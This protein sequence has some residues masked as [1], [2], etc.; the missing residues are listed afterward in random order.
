MIRNSNIAKFI[1]NIELIIPKVSSDY[2]EIWAREYPPPKIDVYTTNQE[3]IKFIIDEKKKIDKFLLYIH[4]PF[5]E[6]KCDYCNYYCGNSID[7]FG[8][9]NYVDCL[10]KEIELN[11]PNNIKKEVISIYFGGGTPSLLNPHDLERL[12]IYLKDKFKLLEGLP[13]TFECS[14]RTV[15]IELAKILKKI[16]VNRI[17]MG[18]Q[19]FNEEILKNV[20]RIQTN[21]DVYNAIKHLRDEGNNN[22]NIE[23]IFGLSYN[24]TITSF[25]NDNAYHLD[26]IM[27]ES[28]MIYKL[29]NYKKHPEM[30]FKTDYESDLL[31]EEMINNI[32]SKSLKFR[33]MIKPIRYPNLPYLINGNVQSDMKNNKHIN[34]LAF[35]LGGGSR[36]WIN[37]QHVKIRHKTNDLNEY[38]FNLVNNILAYKYR[39]LSIDESI[40]KDIIRRLF[41][42]INIRE[43]K[44]LFNNEFDK[45]KTILDKTEN[46]LIEN[47]GIITLKSE[48]EKELPFK[49]EN[50][51]VNYFIFTFCYIYSTE[52][53]TKLLEKYAEI[54][55]A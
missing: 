24:E 50:H 4:I 9:N 6:S 34:E 20:N 39:I 23:L 47:N 53:Q 13:I 54:K 28:V 7:I 36:F 26:K 15:T 44:G 5:C 32:R 51:I 17:S 42:G 45:Y 1:E 38:N 43:I 18:V 49:T 40:R 3:D 16:G 2:C 31:R 48:Y 30:L 19:S 8:S 27:P 22:I 46:C 12:C 37:N 33:Y 10:I 52:M 21:K 14:P 35:G 29:Q 55:E 41:E 11:F 25:I